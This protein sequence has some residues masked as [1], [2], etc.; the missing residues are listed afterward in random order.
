MP[1]HS[2]V[3][4]E[5]ELALIAGEGSITRF[6]I[7][8]CLSS[9]KG[10]RVDRYGKLI[11]LLHAQLVLTNDDIDSV[12]QNLRRY[13]GKGVPGPVA[14]AV[15]NSFNLDMAVLLKQ[16]VPQA[17]FRVFAETGSAFRWLRQQTLAADEMR[18]AS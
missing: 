9:F 11:N 10:H 5:H 8:R 16:R 17:K 4:P 15:Y 18:M 7:K 1:L 14:L 2:A 3:F 13:C 12:G 6:D